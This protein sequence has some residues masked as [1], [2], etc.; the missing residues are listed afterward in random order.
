MPLEVAMIVM[1]QGAVGV[2]LL[3]RAYGSADPRSDEYGSSASS[4]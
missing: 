2:T 4:Q 3:R 1:V